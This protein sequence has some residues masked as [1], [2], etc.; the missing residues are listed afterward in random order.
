MSSTY[1]YSYP[2]WKSYSNI[3]PRPRQGLY[4]G[5]L[6]R[7]GY[8][9][10]YKKSS[11]TTPGG[12]PTPGTGPGTDRPASYPSRAASLAAAAWRQIDWKNSLVFQF[13]PAALPITVQMMAQ[14][15]PD[16]QIPGGNLPT[17]GV[18]LANTNLELFFDRTNEVARATA[19]LPGRAGESKWKNLGVQCDLFD[20]FVLM[21]GGD[22]S[23]L[24]G[25]EP[26]PED[27]ESPGTGPVLPGSLN[28][29]TGVM[30]DAVVTGSKVFFNS[31]AIVFNQNLAV[32]VLR[33]NSLIFT[34]LKFT[35]DL[36]PTQMKVEMGLEITNM[37]TASYVTTTGSTGA[38][39]TTVP[40]PG[41][42][43]ASSATSSTSST[44]R[45]Y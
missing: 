11:A 31:F 41:T 38:A 45:Y 3:P 4:N 36:V 7:H 29:L 18:G 5:M 17:P 27:D 39:D 26:L 15:A 33:L 8:L 20:L 42:T 34:Y 44:M 16:Q 14:D 28:H 37:G 30:L 10:G 19:N 6:L 21:S 32:N 12:A 40:P 35:A 24:T 9:Y 1:K 43:A 2:N 22:A 25:G 13:N 23:L